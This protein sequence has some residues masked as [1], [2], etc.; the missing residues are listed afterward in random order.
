MIQ[1]ITFWNTRYFV[2]TLNIT[3]HSLKRPQK[4]FDY[5]KNSQ[6][7]III[8]GSFVFTIYMQ[9]EQTNYLSQRRKGW[10]SP[11]NGHRFFKDFLRNDPCQRRLN[12]CNRQFFFHY[13]IN[14]KQLLKKKQCIFLCIHQQV[15]Y[16]FI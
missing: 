5:L 1:E 9:I 7:S 10:Y 12:Y 6:V 4:K 16:E 13:V 8:S 11:S 2:E 14:K 15:K 3:I